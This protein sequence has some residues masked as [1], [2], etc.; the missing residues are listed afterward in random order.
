MTNKDWMK[1]RTSDRA[2]QIWDKFVEQHCLKGTGAEPP[3]LWFY[4][5]FAK[6]EAE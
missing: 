6:Q 3:P 2:H 4:F 1:K 5:K